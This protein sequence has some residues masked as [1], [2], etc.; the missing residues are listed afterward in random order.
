MSFTGLTLVASKTPRNF[1][2]GQGAKHFLLFSSTL[3]YG[4][5]SGA[6][7]ITE[8]DE[9]RPLDAYGRSKLEGE[10]AAKR[11]CESA[12]IALT[13]FRPAPI[14]GEG[15]QGN[16]ARLIRTIDKRRFVWVAAAKI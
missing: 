15:S 16:F 5:R 8:E 6:V 2:V 7:P 3:V 11:V 9:C 14:I 1:A 10:N 4:R 13:I 12:G